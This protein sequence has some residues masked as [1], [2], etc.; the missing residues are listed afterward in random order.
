LFLFFHIRKTR[1]ETC[2]LCIWVSVRKL[3]RRVWVQ[4][5]HCVHTVFTQHLCVLFFWPNNK[6]MN[7]KHM[8]PYVL[9]QIFY[10]FLKV[11]ELL[12]LQ[13]L[14]SCKP[15][16][17]KISKT[18]TFILLS[19]FKS[20]HNTRCCTTPKFYKLRKTRHLYLAIP[21]VQVSFMH[22]H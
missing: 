7:S 6:V 1:N 16:F 3:L 20:K 5:R 22:I 9:I 19:P 13:P 2:V 21:C 10:I 18:D 4:K 12:D 15:H 17:L 11:W 8:F 14:F